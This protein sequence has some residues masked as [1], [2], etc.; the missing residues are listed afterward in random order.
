MHDCHMLLS[1]LVGARSISLHAYSTSLARLTGGTSSPGS[2]R[3]KVRAITTPSRQIPNLLRNRIGEM[4]YGHCS[5]G[6]R[7]AKEPFC[8]LETGPLLKR[9]KDPCLQTG[10]ALFIPL[11]EGPL[12][13][14][15]ARD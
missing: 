8:R 12:L 5:P 15:L 9:F 14:P 10:D 11:V 7:N 6:S 3:H 13:D 2:R 4:R 1:D